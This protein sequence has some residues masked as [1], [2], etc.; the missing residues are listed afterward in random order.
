MTAGTTR[1]GIRRW[2][3]PLLVDV[4]AGMLVFGGALVALAL[5]A[6]VGLLIV[7]CGILIAVR[8]A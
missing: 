8:P 6:V 1:A 5:N 4:L 7:I 3:S 2:R